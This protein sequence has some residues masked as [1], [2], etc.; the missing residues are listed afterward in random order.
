MI[1]VR[2]GALVGVKGK[3]LRVQLQRD[4]YDSLLPEEWAATVCGLAA[5]FGAQRWV[6][7]TCVG[8]RRVQRGFL[9]IETRVVIVRSLSPIK[10]LA[11]RASI[12][13]LL[14]SSGWRGFSLGQ[15]GLGVDGLWERLGQS[16]MGSKGQIIIVE[17]WRYKINDNKS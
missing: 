10:R 15:Q 14:Q 1:I 16:T 7:L 11:E 5:G 9:C 13:T 8:R 17:N 3:R 4:S 12:P 2:S 6:S